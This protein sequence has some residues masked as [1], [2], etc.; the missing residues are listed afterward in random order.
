M[1]AV[2]FALPQESQDFRAHLHFPGGADERLTGTV[3]GNIG[4]QEIVVCHT[5]VGP[6]AAERA[7][8]DLLGIYTPRSLVSGGFGG[9][10]EPRLQIGDIV[11]A[12]NFSDLKLLARAKKAHAASGRRLNFGTLATVA[13]AVEDSAEKH[14]LARRTGAMAVDMETSAIHAICHAAGVP[15]I[16]VRAIS[17]T[18]ADALPVP[19]AT[20]F[21]QARQAP[22][23][24]AL[25]RYLARHPARI[26]PFARFVQ[27]VTKARRELTSALLEIVPL[28]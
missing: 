27:G 12:T 22:R 2:T 5:G 23:V 3:I 24:F 1:I 20:W 21:D 4:P 18:A 13:E 8:K 11:A 25:L 9:G 10:L 26:R 14:D 6:A 7:I 28:L 17:D 15:M 19:F 16:S